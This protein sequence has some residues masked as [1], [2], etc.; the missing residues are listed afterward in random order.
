M[1]PRMLRSASRK[2]PLRKL[3][4]VPPSAA[5]LDTMRPSCRTT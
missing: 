1:K 5:N 4:T 2:P 3:L